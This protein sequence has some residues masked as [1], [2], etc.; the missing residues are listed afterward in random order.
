MSF[1]Y[2]LQ[3]LLDGLLMGGIYG[4]VAI[5]LTLIFGVMK[6][7][8]FAHGALMM[9]G[10]Y[11]TYWAFALLHIDP[12]VSIVITIPIL[13]LV[14]V[15]FQK[16]LINPIID[17][18]EHNQLLLTLGVSLFLEN[19]VVFLWSPDYR[20]VKTPY[21]FVYFYI[22]DV[23]I[24]LLRLL[25]FCLAMLVAAVVY[26][27]LTKTDLG[28]AIRASSEEPSGALLVGI[29]VRRI[30]WTTFGI[31]AACAGVSGTAV[32]PFFPVYP[33]VGGIFV[34]TAFMVVVLGGMGS[35]IGAFIGGLIVGMADSVGGLFFPGAMKNLLS[36]VIFILILLFRPTGLFGGSK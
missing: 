6:V 10:M 2:I 1:T 33:T 26:L 5:G 28:K 3:T 20:V 4:L 12:Y 34:I 19:I 22:G 25:A 36:F 7:I 32:A 13:F 9:L 18:P 21:E 8:N 30:Y 27:V 15:C 14:G 29:N 23:S 31:G 11:A 16:F 24:S 17:A 35:V